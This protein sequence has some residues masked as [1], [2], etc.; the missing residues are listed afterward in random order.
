MQKQP[1]K[2]TIMYYITSLMLRPLGASMSRVL[3]LNFSFLLNSHPLVS[4]TKVF[5]TPLKNFLCP[6]VL[7]WLNE[8]VCLGSKPLTA[9]RLFC[10]QL[11][12]HNLNLST[13]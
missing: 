5:A 4:S 12:Q 6:S 7:K 2:V 11:F 3:I 8:Y 9:F 10:L 13:S 1:T